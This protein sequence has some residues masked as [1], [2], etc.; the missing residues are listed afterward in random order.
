VLQ[1]KL[2][3]RTTTHARTVSTVERSVGVPMRTRNVPNSDRIGRRA[4]DHTTVADDSS[5]LSP[6]WIA[7]AKVIAEIEVVRAVRF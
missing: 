5:T 1:T 2:A 3:E 7:A 4:A 6:V